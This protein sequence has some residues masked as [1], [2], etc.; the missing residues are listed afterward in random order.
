MLISVLIKWWMEH[1]LLQRAVRIVGSALLGLLMLGWIV[2][3]AGPSKGTVVVHVIGKDLQVRI[4]PESFQFRGGMRPIVCKLPA[5]EYTLTLSRGDRMLDEQH[6]QVRRGEW[7]T[8][9]T[10]DRK[11]YRSRPADR[12]ELVLTDWANDPASTV[13][14]SRRGPTPIRRHAASR[15]CSQPGS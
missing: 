6:F 13:T 9:S 5:G 7:T 10:F 3:I 14:P 11:A 15:R 8:L 2:S 1:Y 4:G 12:G